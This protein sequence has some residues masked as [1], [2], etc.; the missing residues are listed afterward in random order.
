MKI[1]LAD[2]VICVG[3][4]LIDKKK[5]GVDL[6]KRKTYNAIRNEFFT[7]RIRF[8]ILKMIVQDG[9]ASGREKW[10]ATHSIEKFRL[11]NM[12]WSLPAADPAVRPLQEYGADCHRRFDG[13]SGIQKNRRGI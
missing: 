10:K 13:R 5:S 12:I 2:Q 6:R 8:Q 11:R 3:L 4:F 1:I 7:M 9:F